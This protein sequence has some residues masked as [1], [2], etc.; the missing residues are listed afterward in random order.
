MN[1]TNQVDNSTTQT[2]DNYTYYTH[3]SHPKIDHKHMMANFYVKDFKV[4]SCTRWS[5]VFLSPEARGDLIREREKLKSLT[6]IN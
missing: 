6:M 5:S 3:N 1:C 2:T 4:V